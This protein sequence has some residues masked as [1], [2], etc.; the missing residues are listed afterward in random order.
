MK[1]LRLLPLLLLL[2]GC[3]NSYR[4]VGTTREL[5]AGTILQAA[6]LERIDDTHVTHWIWAPSE[7]YATDPSE[8][9]GR[10]LLVDTAKHQLISKN[11]IT[12]ITASWL[13]REQLIAKQ[14]SESRQ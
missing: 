8:L 7:L 12:P 4:L 1:N 10:K 13:R 9:V 6:D 3:V 14:R 5:P 2:T 11:C